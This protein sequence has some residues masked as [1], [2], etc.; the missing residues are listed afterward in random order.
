MLIREHRRTAGLSQRQLADL[1]RVSIGVIRDLEQRRTVY[2]QPRSV[3]SLVRALG[4]NHGQAAALARAAR[5]GMAGAGTVAA[6]SRTGD[7]TLCP[8]RH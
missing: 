8:A 2:L 1:A 7:R 6:R 3:E 5:P 4:L